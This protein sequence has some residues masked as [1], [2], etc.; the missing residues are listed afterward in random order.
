MRKPL[1]IV[2]LAAVLPALGHS[3]TVNICERAPQVRDT[4][5][6]ALETDD[7][8]AVDSAKPAELPEDAFGGGKPAGDRLQTDLLRQRVAPVAHDVVRGISKAAED[9]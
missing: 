2:L 1:T 5:M 3:Q 7:C 6:Q 9:D 4:I 8:D